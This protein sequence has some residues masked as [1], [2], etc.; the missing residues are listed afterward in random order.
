MS[1]II[2]R[3]F[4]QIPNSIL[5]DDTIGGTAYKYYGYINYRNNIS[6][7]W[8]F[9]NQ[10]IINH[11]KE[12][13]VAISTAR[14][15]LLEGLYLNKITQ[16]R[17]S[18]GCFSGFSYEI[19]EKKIK[20]E[21]TSNSASD[22]IEEDKKTKHGFT[23]VPNEVLLDPKISGLAF[24]I[25]C[26]ILYRMSLQ[27]KYD[28]TS[29][30]WSFFN[31]EM[32][33]HLK[34]GRIA[35]YRA[36]QELIDAGYLQKIE[37]G[38]KN[39]GFG[40]CLYKIF[41]FIDNK[42]QEPQ[43][44]KETSDFVTSEN[45]A[46]N[47]IDINNKEKEKE[48][49]KVAPQGDLSF[50]S[51]ENILSKTKDF[52]ST[53][54]EKLQKCYLELRKIITQRTI[55]I[56]E[57]V[58]VEYLLLVLYRN[59]ET[60]KALI[61]HLISQ[62]KIMYERGQDVINNLK[63]A[64]IRQWK[65]WQPEYFFNDD[66]KYDTVNCDNTEDLNPFTQHSTQAIDDV[67]NTIHKSFQCIK[68]AIINGENEVI[69]NLPAGDGLKKARIKAIETLYNSIKYLS[70]SNKAQRCMGISDIIRL[71]SDNANGN[72]IWQGRE[73]A[74]QK[75][76]DE[77]NKIKQSL[78]QNYNTIPK[79]TL[80][81]F[82]LLNLTLSSTTNNSIERDFI[83]LSRQNILVMLK[84]IQN[85][86]KKTGSKVN[87]N[88]LLKKIEHYKIYS[89]LC[90][91]RDVNKN[92]TSFPREETLQLVCGKYDATMIAIEKDMLLIE[93]SIAGTEN[94]INHTTWMTQY[95]NY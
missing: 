54:T 86:K 52:I 30:E 44:E 73:S 53:P 67:A 33:S 19:N 45:L 68:K 65:S 24:K 40:S 69:Q 41:P 14:Q 64:A 5:F 61:E 92:F 2:T 10:E 46:T 66:M 81:N 32:M 71:P 84:Y 90:V 25:Y 31:K 58:P 29:F 57:Y 55:K 27:S 75:I 56:P 87:L 8:R 88:I 13:K 12:K 6:S 42:S 1:Y 35:F 94:V 34:E 28:N 18:G 85:D 51:F 4:T 7:E 48:R 82:N 77:D 11:F 16:K 93:R 20:K 72:L 83:E 89:I 59:K 63:K 95:E 80:E 50:P 21:L 74:L 49:V 15:Q 43:S 70:Y 17:D 22:I 47:N 38:R 26:Y 60:T 3:N 62:A 91:L 23:Q 36:K 76:Y 79:Q 37:Q 9:Y 39:N 78:L